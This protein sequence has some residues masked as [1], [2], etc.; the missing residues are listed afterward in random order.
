MRRR[1]LLLPLVPLYSAGLRL[2]RWLAASRGVRTRSLKSPVLSVGSLSAGGA[3]KTPVVL[4]LA[5]LLAER[6]YAVSILTRGYKRSST[7]TERVLPRGD[8]ARFGDEPLLLANRSKLPVYVGADR[9]LA[10]VMAESGTAGVHLLDDGFQHRRLARDLDLVLLTAEDV[11]D[12][13]LP[14]G[15]LREPLT[16]LSRAGAIVVRQ[17][18]AGALAKIVTELTV[19]AEPIPI[20]LIRRALHLPITGSPRP[21][22]PLVFCGIARPGNFTAMLGAESITPAGVTAFADHHRYRD[23]DITELLARARDSQA[24]GFVTTEKDAVK[25]SSG[26]RHRLEQ[27]GP[28]LIPELTVTFLDER[29]AMDQLIAL[30]PRLNRRQGGR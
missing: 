21:R 3:G 25:L 13:L 28:L 8:P 5:N 30:A 27:F 11:N 24:D 14:A 7:V 18:E 1:P 26:M 20:L 6:G 10:G 22:H 19:E 16:S 15:N 2:D 23:R 9:Y 4:A 17:E 29:A 12:S